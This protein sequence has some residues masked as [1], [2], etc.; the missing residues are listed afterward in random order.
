MPRDQQEPIRYADVL[1][2]IASGAVWSAYIDDT[3]PGGKSV[4]PATLPHDRETHV[5]AVFPPA[6]GAALMNQMPG[7]LE[8]LRLTGGE[9]EFHFVHIYNGTGPYRRLP[10][11]TRLAFF[12]F[13][14]DVS[15]S[16][17][18]KFLVQSIDAAVSAN[19]R[20]F[21]AATLEK[22]PGF[23]D[24][25]SNKDL[26]RFFLFVKL[27]QY[28]SERLAP[29]ECAA[30]FL[31]QGWK[32]NGQALSV[33]RWNPPFYKGL[34]MSA[35]SRNIW[36]LQFADFAAFVLNRSQ[37]LV[38]RD[39][40]SSVDTAFLKMASTIAPLF[41]GLRIEERTLEADAPDGEG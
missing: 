39:S 34:V 10:I 15:V 17:G 13:F 9:S 11:A 31:D 14:A 8:E 5:A 40:L 24:P 16:H 27:R 29:Q 19:V 41:V 37:I 33:P 21:A 36:G 22:T 6:A 2:L 23:F 26:S 18:L 30:V 12:E 38:G 20:E 3:G 25:N 7:A 32:A 4:A 35:D 28:L 1:A